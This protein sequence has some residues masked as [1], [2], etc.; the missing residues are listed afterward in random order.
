MT[1]Q[2]SGNKVDGANRLRLRTPAADPALSAAQQAAVSGAVADDGMAGPNHH[3]SGLLV[4]LS[5]ILLFAAGGYGLYKVLTYSPSTAES[6]PSSASEAINR[7][8][9]VRDEVTA[10][11]ARLDVSADVIVGESEDPVLTVFEAPMEASMVVTEAT[12]GDANG[13]TMADEQGSATG[14]SEAIGQYLSERFIG[15]VRLGETDPRVILDGRSYSRGE[16]IEG[17]YEIRFV[18]AREGV[19]YFQDDKG[20]T[21]RR[22]F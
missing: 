17:P 20:I 3:K 7:S 22:R 2:G 1:E 5:L 19:L 15:S 4:V 12:S 21:Y 13:T 18:A 8:T 6:Q 10:N 14:Q 16:R 9:R 11:R